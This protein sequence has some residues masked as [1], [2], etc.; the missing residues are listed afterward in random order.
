MKLS[1]RNQIAGKVLSVSKGTIMAKVRID[2][3]GGNSITSIITSDS[4]DDL[5]LKEGDA[6]T[7]IIKATSIMLGK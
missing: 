6:V 5:A 2:I 1:A 7:A 3:G 4:A